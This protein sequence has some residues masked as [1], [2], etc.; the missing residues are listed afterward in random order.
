MKVLRY[1]SLMALYFKSQM[2]TSGLPLVDSV[3]NDDQGKGFTTGG[4]TQ[5][6]ALHHPKLQH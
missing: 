3:V 1:L 4:K 6:V 2:C 5:L